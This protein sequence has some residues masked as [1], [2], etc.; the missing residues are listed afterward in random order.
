MTQ[1][2]PRVLGPKTSRLLLGYY[3]GPN[4]PMKLRLWGY[5]MAALGNP[6][7]TV[8]Y[9]G[10]PITL[11]IRDW[12]QNEILVR[13]SF[14]S[15][16]WEA[17]DAVATQDEVFWDIGAH[18]G[19]VALRAAGDRRFKEVQA[20]EPHPETFTALK[21]NTELNAR[22]KEGIL[23]ANPIALSDK[24]EDRELFVGLTAN[25]G[26]ASFTSRWGT[27]SIQV[28]TQ[29]LDG[30]IAR[31]F[32]PPTLI[33]IDTEGA[34]KA[35]LQGA[36]VLLKQKPPKKIVFES[37]LAEGSIRD[38]KLAEILEK[39][40][41]RIQPIVGKGETR[42]EVLSRSCCNWEATLK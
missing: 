39:S 41:Y 6:R 14:D 3:L 30:L 36:T 24:A 18:I 13:G 32:S 1:A 5:L 40:G 27:K 38:K 37:E 15:D 9:F 7:F 35:V 19:S 25:Q 26:L 10:K 28:S 29:T 34:E 31:G 12:I 22:W 8:D 42:L 17:M 2:L 21:K 16:V 20:F 11:D 23:Q 33:K 4:H